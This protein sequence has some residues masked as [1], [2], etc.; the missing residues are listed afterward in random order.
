MFKLNKFIK[1]LIYK[2]ANKNNEYKWLNQHHLYENGDIL[3]FNIEGKQLDIARIQQFLQDKVKIN[4]YW[5]DI[6]KMDIKNYINWSLLIRNS[7]KIEKI[8]NKELDEDIQLN[9]YNPVLDYINENSIYL[10]EHNLLNKITNP[11]F[12]NYLKIKIKLFY[13][14]YW[15]NA[16]LLDIIDNRYL[17]VVFKDILNQKFYNLEWSYNENDLYKFQYENEYFKKYIE[18]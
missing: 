6:N 11:D 8:I 4:G 17:Y 7:K 15:I 9:L 13:E 16:N 12:D 2:K 10:N 18:F 1:N 3:V 5:I 14:N